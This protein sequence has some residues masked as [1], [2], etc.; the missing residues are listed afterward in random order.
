MTSNDWSVIDSSC[1]RTDSY[2]ILYLAF[3]N[4]GFSYLRTLQTRYE[5]IVLQFL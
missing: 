4:Y 2:G 3:K 1:L 5:S